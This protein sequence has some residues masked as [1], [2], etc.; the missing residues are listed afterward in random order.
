MA[1]G[2]LRCTVLQV[3]DEKFIVKASSGPRYLVGVR[4]RVPKDQ[5]KAGKRVTLDMTTLTIMRIL[6]REV[7][8][9]STGDAGYPPTTIDYPPIA[10]SHPPTSFGYPPKPP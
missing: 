5:L 4:S 6:P 2:S 1:L 7:P 8:S 3:D 9:H 10:V